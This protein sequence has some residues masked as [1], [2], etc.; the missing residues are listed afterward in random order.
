MLKKISFQSL[1]LIILAL[2]L[3]LIGESLFIWKLEDSIHTFTNALYVVFGHLLFFGRQTF[4]I[5]NSS[6]I[7]LLTMTSFLGIGIQGFALQWLFTKVDGFLKGAKGT[8]Q[9][10]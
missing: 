10:S 7:W 2:L 8:S 4:M 1:T 6:S 3:L 5:E 9:A